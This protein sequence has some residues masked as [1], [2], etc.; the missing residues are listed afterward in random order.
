MPGIFKSL[1]TAAGRPTES[2]ASAASPE[3]AVRTV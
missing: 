3:M 2:P 1:I